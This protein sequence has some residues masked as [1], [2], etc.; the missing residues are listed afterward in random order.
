MGNES[1]PEM[2]ENYQTLKRLSAREDFTERN[3]GELSNLEEV[4]CPRRFY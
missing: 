4:V 2:L 3:V 1:V